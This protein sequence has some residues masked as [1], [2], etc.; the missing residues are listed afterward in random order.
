MSLFGNV[1]ARSAL[2]Q[3]SQTRPNNAKFG[4]VV[5]GA[6]ASN[7]RGNVASFFSVSGAVRTERAIFRTLADSLTT[8]TG[9]LASARVGAERLGGILDKAEALVGAA[10][11][12]APSAALKGSFD[13]LES[14]AA[15]SIAQ[16]S[17][18][19]TNLLSEGSEL[20]VTFGFDK[21]G[22]GY[23]FRQLSFQTTGLSATQA[24]IDAAKPRTETVDVTLGE[25][26]TGRIDRLQERETR[27]EDRQD[28][29]QA[30]VDRLD[31]R[32]T[33]LQDRVARFDAIEQR[34]NDRLTN[35]ADRGRLTPDR[36]ARI[37][38]RLDRVAERRDAVTER[39]GT[40]GERITAVNERLTKTTD[41]ITS[42]Q[43][44]I[45]RTTD[46]LD[47]VTA[48]GRVNEVVDTRTV[49][50]AP[51]G[52][53]PA[54]GFEGLVSQ[55]ADRVAAGDTEGA[56]ALIEAGRER[57]DRLDGQLDRISGTIER[58]GGL[59]GQITARLDDAV[60]RRID[61]GL[62]DQ[63]AARAAAAMLGKLD[64]LNRLFSDE[65]RPGVLALFEPRS[66]ANEGTSG[67]RVEE[68]EES[69]VGTE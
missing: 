13:M 22:A 53:A 38:A 65:G 34:L 28:R 58:Q 57:L 9:S 30:R 46:R 2:Q 16:G 56:R 8:A 12:G 43:E 18:R 31:A 55:I 42:T 11:S 51:E 44:R 21:S 69:S 52:P 1:Q 20:T 40:L 63:S 33:K 54:Q 48:N 14:K 68:L 41:R 3:F 37:E 6:R 47:R 35:L 7:T 67:Q 10:E 45:T 15:Q 5:T 29:L 64:G 27:L 32:Q 19:G 49:E 24:E 25:K 39:L 23:D 66:E 62:D 36:Q 61:K 17:F 4:D 60:E 50:V 26:L 59:F